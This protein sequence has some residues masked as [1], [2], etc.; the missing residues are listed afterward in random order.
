MSGRPVHEEGMKSGAL[1]ALAFHGHGGQI[2]LGAIRRRQRTKE[3]ILAAL[4]S[5]PTH[6]S[7]HLNR[8]LLESVISQVESSY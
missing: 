8:S 2:A 5:I 1:I 4:R 7:L 3:E 6:S